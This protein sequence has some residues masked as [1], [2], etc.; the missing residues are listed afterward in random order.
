MA[1]KVHLEGNK[2]YL[3]SLDSFTLR[4]PKGKKEVYRTHAQSRSESLNGFL[5]KAV[6]E[7]M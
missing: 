2:R 3:N 1:T 5:S 7:A 4:M 6:D